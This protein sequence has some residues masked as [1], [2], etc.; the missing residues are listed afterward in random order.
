MVSHPNFY[1]LPVMDVTNHLLSPMHSTAKRAVSSLFATLK[2][3][4]NGLISAPLLLALNPLLMN[5]PSSSGPPTILI[6][7]PPHLLNTSILPL[8]PLKPMP[9][10]IKESLA[11]G[12][13]NASQF[14][15]PKSLTPTAYHIPQRIHN[16]SLITLNPTK[17]SNMKKHAINAVVTSLP[18][19]TPSMAS[20]QKEK[21]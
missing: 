19:Y 14:S 20:L 18:S 7:P 4:M 11:F 8:S 1:L 16:K 15:M 10:E 12:N 3:L 21:S 2:L 13:D 5:P 6:I 9:G 17:K